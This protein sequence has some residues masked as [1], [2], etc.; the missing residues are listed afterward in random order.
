MSKDVTIEEQIKIT[1]EG[2][3]II[4]K[5]ENGVILYNALWEIYKPKSFLGDFFNKFKSISKKVF[6]RGRRQI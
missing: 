2:K 1:I 6:K 3:E 4:L 5:K